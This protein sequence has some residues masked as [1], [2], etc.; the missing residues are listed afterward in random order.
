MVELATAPYDDD[1]IPF[2][3]ASVVEIDAELS[4]DS[5]ITA[6]AVPAASLVS[7]L[8]SS[9]EY[10]PFVVQA[11]TSEG[12]LT[13]ISSI[14]S[15]GEALDQLPDHDRQRNIAAGTA[16]AVLG[17]FL[18]GP[19]VSLV[20][21]F[22]TGYY[23]KQEGAAGDIARAL[24]D[25]ALMTREKF[26]E[27]DSEHH[28]VDRSRDAAYEAFQR[29]QHSNQRLH[30][31]EK[32]FQFTVDCWRSTLAFVERHNLVERGCRAVVC[33]AAHIITKMEKNHRRTRQ[34]PHAAST[35]GRNFSSQRG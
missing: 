18:G 17:L 28:I 10:A 19:F 30:V 14:Q 12:E 13:E 6:E 21:G 34:C 24:G 8:P 4:E 1:N 35:T 11:S 25:V 32:V 20:L 5:I 7:S 9:G 3:T 16:G 23:A 26:R 2:V 31:R 29:F 22:G 15:H 27:V 33:I